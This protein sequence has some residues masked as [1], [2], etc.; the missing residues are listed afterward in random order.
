MSYDPVLFAAL[1]VWS[2]F[3]WEESKTGYCGKEIMYFLILQ[4]QKGAPQREAKRAAKWRHKPNSQS[5]AAR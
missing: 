1:M 3:P 5:Y 2:I 4:R